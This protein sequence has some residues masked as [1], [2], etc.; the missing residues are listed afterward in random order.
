MVGTLGDKQTEWNGK[1][2]GDVHT[3]D[4]ETGETGGMAE[5][6]MCEPE[7]GQMW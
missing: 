6:Q 2:G 4:G 3:R 1:K 5:C 7:T